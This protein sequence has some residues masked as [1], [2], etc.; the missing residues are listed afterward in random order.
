[1]GTSE[2]LNDPYLIGG[3][4][5]ASGDGSVLPVVIDGHSYLVDTSRNTPMQERFRRSSLQLLNTQ[6]NLDKGESAL[7]T[8]EVWRRTYK[9]WHHGMGQRFSDREDS[10]SYRYDWSKGIN[11]WRQWEFSLLHETAQV[12]TASTIAG[13]MCN[14]FSVALLST[15]TA[16][17]VNDGVDSLASFTLPGPSLIA[18]DGYFLYALA[19]MNEKS[20]LYRYEVTKSGS[21]ISVTLKAQADVQTATRM[22]LLLF[23]NYKLIATST[24]GLVYDLTGYAGPT[25]PTALPSPAYTTPVP[26]QTFVAGCSGKK[27]IYLMSVQGDQ[28]AVHAFDII[29]STSNGPLD[30][31][32]Y[33]G[34]AALLPDGEIGVSLYSYLG[35]VAIGTNKGFRFAAVSEGSEAITYGP[36]IETPA[37]VTAFE[38]QDRFLYY[39]LKD[40]RG[41]SGIGRADLSQFT[42]D[43]Q[44]AYASDLMSTG[45]RSAS[46]TFINTLHSG[47]IMFGLS[48]AGVWMEQDTYVT[49]GQLQMSAWTFNV[50]DPKT[51][52]YVTTQSSLSDGGG[53]NLAVIYDQSGNPVLLGDYQEANQKFTLSGMPFQSAG[54]L[55]TLYAKADRTAGPKVY[56]YE[57]RSTY[58]RGKAS[59]WQVPCILHDEIEQDNGTVQARDVVS[60]YQ[61]L[62]NLVET[63]KQFTYIEDSQQWEVYA[64]DF[65]W[66]PHERSIDTGW[67]GVFT[68]YFR[69]VR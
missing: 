61:H 52:L 58:I 54:L 59:E 6:Q 29:R 17:Y 47:K 43:L 36:L 60:D 24:N 3:I 12:S 18:T 32:I 10:D 28:S 44:P 8:P 55:A 65:I 13:V 33:S 68:I 30:T 53:G 26:G 39:A 50:V 2:R 42:A 11:P 51:G 4:P 38:G 40:F 20:T 5:G 57:M 31:L 19:E 41:D 69:E 9:S 56:S 7:V 14:G 22:N 45:N 23:A 63:G 66:S 49:E 27:A 46:V 37:P 64:T 48:G 16:V 1:M 15:R 35:Y 67:Q 34:V 21:T 25:P 62:M